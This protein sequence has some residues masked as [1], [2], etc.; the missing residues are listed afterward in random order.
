MANAGYVISE[1]SLED[2]LKKLKNIP[3]HRIGTLM[4]VHGTSARKTDEGI[5]YRIREHNGQ[6]LYECAVLYAG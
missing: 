4:P 2:M 1:K 3:F 5:P 6:T